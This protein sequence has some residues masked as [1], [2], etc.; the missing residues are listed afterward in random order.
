[1]TTAPRPVPD[2]SI[3]PDVVAGEPVEVADRVVRVTAPN[4]SIMT[5]PGTNTYLVGRREVVVIDPGPVLDGHLD[6]IER[7]VADA[8]G[9]IRWIAVTHH[10][11]DHAPGAVPLAERTGAELLAF[12]HPE[13]VDPDRPV[14]EGFVLA[15]PDFRLR[16][17]HTPGHASDHLCWLFEEASLLFSGDHVMQG[18]TVVIRPPDANMADYLANLTRLA[19]LD[20]PIATIAPGHGRL[21]GD[22]AGVIGSIVRH[23]LQ[24]E[25][26]VEAALHDRG[27]ATIEDLLPRVYADVSEP[28]LAVARFSLWAHLQK[29]AADGRA[30]LADADES[31]PLRSAI[32]SSWEAVST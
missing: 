2:S 21:I 27:R 19:H 11:R 28:L 1:M 24:R 13:G 25:D 15:G 18:S 8:G 30:R 23:R 20:P 32:A 5:G 22:P 31:D 16:A 4:P 9:T 29:L 26:L 3:G 17:L 14:K 6:V 7:A 10:H 12:G